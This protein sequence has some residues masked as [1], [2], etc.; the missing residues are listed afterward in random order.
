[1]IEIYLRNHR[2]LRH[3]HERQ[4]EFLCSSSDV[5][6]ETAIGH[7]GHD[8]QMKGEGPPSRQTPLRLIMLG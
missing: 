8:N 6:E 7:E 3:S 4:L 5:R 1:M 2:H